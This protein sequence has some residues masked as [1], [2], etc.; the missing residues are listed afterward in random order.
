MGVGDLISQV[1]L[2]WKLNGWLK[3]PTHGESVLVMVNWMVL[4][5]MKYRFTQE[6]NG[7]ACH[8]V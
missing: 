8:E 6:R 2:P 5:V 7:N 3:S 4:C 1:G